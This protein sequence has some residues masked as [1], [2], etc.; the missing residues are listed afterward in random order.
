ME[1]LSGVKIQNKTK[2]QLETWSEIRSPAAGCGTVNSDFQNNNSTRDCHIFECSNNQRVGQLVTTHKHVICYIIWRLRFETCF[3]NSSVISGKKKTP[4][5]AN[6]VGDLVLQVQVSLHHQEETFNEK[7]PF[8][9]HGTQIYEKIYCY[10]FYWE[11][12]RTR[13][14]NTPEL[15]TSIE[16]MIMNGSNKQLA[17]RKLGMLI[18]ERLKIVFKVA[19]SI[20]YIVA[21]SSL[22]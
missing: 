11:E 8:S 14:K 2:G 16:G 20:I 18:S 15:T 22:P 10:Q 6:D 1:I 9:V 19:L 7:T 21:T 12:L 4:K 17:L 13:E 3:G 5:L